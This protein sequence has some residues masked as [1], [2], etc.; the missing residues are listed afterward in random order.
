MVEKK[1][2]QEA[3]AEDLVF[4]KWKLLGYE[5]RPDYT[6]YIYPVHVWATNRILHTMI[7]RDLEYF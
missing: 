1:E 6:L 7:S 4:R 3:I 2:E 5:L